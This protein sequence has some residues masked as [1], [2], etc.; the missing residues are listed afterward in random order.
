MLITCGIP[1]LKLSF[2][3]IIEDI[4]IFTVLVCSACYTL[5]VFEILCFKCIGVTTCI[6]RSCD[7]I[8]HMT[9]GF[10]IGHFLLGVLWNQGS[11]SND[12]RDM[13]RQM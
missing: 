6:F 5:P 4:L 13:Q 10:S 9:I 1:K 7:I 3:A 12:F 11:I 8:G 2:V